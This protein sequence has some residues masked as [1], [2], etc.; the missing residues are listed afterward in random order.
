MPPLTGW[1]LQWKKTPHKAKN[2]SQQSSGSWDRSY[3]PLHHLQPQIFFNYC[4]H[5]NSHPHWCFCPT[6]PC[7]ENCKWGDISATVS[8]K[9][10]ETAK[11]KAKKAARCKKDGDRGGIWGHCS[12][13]KEKEGTES[14]TEGQR[15]EEQHIRATVL[16]PASIQKAGKYR[17]TQQEC[18]SSKV[19]CPPWAELCPCCCLQGSSP[20]RTKGGGSGYRE[21]QVGQYD[22]KE[23]VEG[24]VLGVRSPSPRKPVH[25]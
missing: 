16:L 5:Y 13:A 20:S 21:T 19:P 4:H 18:H 24:V 8:Q 6:R 3:E 15:W 25:A 12:Q 14:K 7:T 2:S 22:G 23:R 11:I 10:K 1:Q 17:I 9:K